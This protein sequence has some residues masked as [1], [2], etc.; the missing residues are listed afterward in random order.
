MSHEMKANLNIKVALVDGKHTKSRFGRSK[1]DES[2]QKVEDSA[3]VSRFGEIIQ[4]IKHE[5]AY[6][7]KLFESS[8]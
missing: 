7:N 8:D 6:K 1:L 4:D 5:M 3:D 2:S